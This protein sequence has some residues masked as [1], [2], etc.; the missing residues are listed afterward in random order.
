M[1]SQEEINEESFKKKFKE[2]CKELDNKIYGK[3]KE[4]VSTSHND[5]NDISS[6]C[7]CVLKFEETKQGSLKLTWLRRKISKKYKLLRKLLK[8]VQQT[9]SHI[10]AM[11]YHKMANKIVALE[12]KLKAETNKPINCVSDCKFCW[13]ARKFLNL[14]RYFQYGK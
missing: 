7:A 5:L 4:N 9:G 8:R 3:L 6:A 12:E 11:K 10:D 13:N 1:A 14:K 2:T